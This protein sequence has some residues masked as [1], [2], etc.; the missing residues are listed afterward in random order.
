VAGHVEL[1]LT[2]LTTAG[3]TA[4]LDVLVNGRGVLSRDLPAGQSRIAL[5]LPISA[6]ALAEGHVRLSLRYAAAASASRCRDRRLGGVSLAIDPGSALTLSAP[7]P[8][9]DAEALALLP[10]EV[11]FALPA[12]PLSPD[13]YRALLAAAVAL[14][15]TGHRLVPRAAETA[16]VV[17]SRDIAV[18]SLRAD[19]VL[20]LPLSPQPD[21]PR[22]RPSFPLG[23]ADGA[24]IPLSALG[25]ESGAREAYMTTSWRFALPEIPAGKIPSAL[26]LSF[27]H[28]ADA[29]GIHHVVHLLINGTLASSAE[30][31]P[32]NTEPVTLPIPPGLLGFAKQ[33]ELIFERITKA[34]CLDAA[35]PLPVALVPS[36]R[37][38][39]SAAPERAR[40][41]FEIAEHARGGLALYLPAA[42][43]ADPGPSLPFLAGLLKDYWRPGAALDL[44]DASAAPPAP[45]HPFLLIAGTP[46]AAL[47]RPLRA[48]ASDVLIET[49]DQRPVLSLKPSEGG[50]ALLARLGTQ[51]GIWIAPEAGT[52]ALPAEI[53][54]EHGD[55]AVFD[56][57]GVA[58]WL[59]T[60]APRGLA[61]RYADAAGLGPLAASLIGKGWLFGSAALWCL[62]TLATLI[63]L[64]RR[65][66][67]R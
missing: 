63:T 46:P 62:I 5:R 12:G 66:L 54:L 28:G 41:F 35:A 56:R 29:P 13:E 9:G 11:G 16:H 58:L 34:G 7:P 48:D 26:A 37:L 21:A 60:Q 55:V 24:S 17:F 57:T 4:V 42:F 27:A 53:K 14:A 31:A 10:A 23:A 33:A 47:T 52:A 8:R 39:L 49:R 36:A 32:G 2:A 3:F 25:A 65:G 30:L 22:E 19:G 45:A 15:R 1:A 20:L 64:A 67:R 50:F 51:S 6:D 44:H 18:P 38:Q 40:Q 59:N 43:F 61:L